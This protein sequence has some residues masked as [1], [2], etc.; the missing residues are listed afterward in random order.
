MLAGF[1][2]AGNKPGGCLT[3][4]TAPATGVAD[5]TKSA[6][7]TMPGQNIDEDASFKTAGKDKSK[8][9]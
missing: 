4:V 3:T 6:E 7:I 2:C 1:V 9:T 8:V 5:A